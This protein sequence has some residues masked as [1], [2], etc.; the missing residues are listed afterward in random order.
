MYLGRNALNPFAQFGQKFFDAIILQDQSINTAFS[1]AIFSYDQAASQSDKNMVKP[2]LTVKLEN[3][4]KFPWLTLESGTVLTFLP[5]QGKGGTRVLDTFLSWA[6]TFQNMQQTKLKYSEILALLDP[7]RDALVDRYT[8]LTHAKIAFKLDQAVHQGLFV[9]DRIQVSEN[10]QNEDAWLTSQLPQGVRLPERN[11]DPQPKKSG[12]KS[13]RLVL[14]NSLGQTTEKTTRQIGYDSNEAWV[15]DLHPNRLKQ[16]SD[17]LNE[18]GRDSRQTRPSISL[19]EDV[20]RIF[21]QE[22]VNNRRQILDQ[23]YQKCIEEKDT[24][25]HQR[26]FSI[27]M[28]KSIAKIL[29]NTNRVMQTF[30]SESIALSYT[31]RLKNE[32]MTPEIFAS[33]PRVDER[34]NVRLY[35]FSDGEQVIIKRLKDFI[36]NAGGHEIAAEFLSV[37]GQFDLVG[38]T[39]HFE[40]FGHQYIVQEY[41]G[42]MTEGVTPTPQSN[43]LVDDIFTY[44]A[45]KAF[46]FDFLSSSSDRGL[47]RN[48]LVAEDG[49][50]RLIDHEDSFSIAMPNTE[51]VEAIWPTTIARILIDLYP[52]LGEGTPNTGSWHDSWQHIIE[53]Y[54]TETNF[55]EVLQ[56]AVCIARDHIISVADYRQT[57]GRE[58]IFPQTLLIEEIQSFNNRLDYVLNLLGHCE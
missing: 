20:Q 24:A 10:T 44:Y 31:Q 51:T 37:Y 7:Y 5:S 46:I 36:V 49:S 3:I 47:D 19:Q 6:Q 45:A 40:V 55:Q 12:Y 15:S 34:G 33:L 58:N 21:N 1:Q 23:A 48:I 26:T 28:C 27:E 53:N 2:Y 14:A 41:F 25:E 4:D 18:R 57:V 39:E 30:S 54:Q 22:H 43:P 13:D 42:N 56:R 16:L 9:D 52:D 17:Q 35:T 38:R 8:D 11:N 32:R 29:Q 50:I